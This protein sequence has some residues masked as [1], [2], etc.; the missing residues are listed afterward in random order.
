MRMPPH[1]D[2][3]GTRTGECDVLGVVQPV[4]DTTVLTTGF[5]D[6]IGAVRRGRWWQL[7]LGIICMS[8]IANLQYGWTLF[9]QPMH[10]ARGW[11]LSSVLVLK[12][13]RTCVSHA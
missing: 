10:D 12:P 2:G 9:V 3:P 1:S 6:T 7:V 11:P 13:M 8:M 5:A 4:L